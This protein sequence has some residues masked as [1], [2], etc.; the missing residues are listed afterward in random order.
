MPS[1]RAVP[2]TERIAAS[3]S[4]VLRSTSFFWA[5]STTLGL[6]EL[7]D[8]VLVG[9]GRALVRANS[10]HQKDDVGGV[11]SSIVKDLSEY[12]VITTGIT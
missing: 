8:L 4:S 6:G 10:L 12:T 7:P 3:R 5:I 1:D 2:F 9:T 11:L